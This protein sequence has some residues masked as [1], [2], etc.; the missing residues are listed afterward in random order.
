MGSKAG[1]LSAFFGATLGMLLMGGAVQADPWELRN[2]R[3][4]IEREEAKL[5]RDLRRHGLG[6]RQAEQRRLKLARLYRECGVRSGRDWRGVGGAVDRQLGRHGRLHR[7]AGHTGGV[8]LL[9]NGGVVVLPRA[10]HGRGR[11]IHGHGCGH[12]RS[13][14]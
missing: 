14:W 9:P 2:C 11:H 4:R 5:L 13:R 7:G 6:S 12:P 1:W 8:V 10:A 3:T